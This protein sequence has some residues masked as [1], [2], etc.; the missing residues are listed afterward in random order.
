MISDSEGLVD[1]LPLQY[2]RHK[3]IAI[4]VQSCFITPIFLC[5]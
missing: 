4:V 3:G 5:C 2:L 1:D